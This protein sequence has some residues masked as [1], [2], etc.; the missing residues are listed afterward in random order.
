M[1]NS[2]DQRVTV[3]QQVKTCKNCIIVRRLSVNQIHA[4][5]MKL[6]I[7]LNIVYAE[8]HTTVFIWV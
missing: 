8:Y 7:S 2:R 4:E 6:Y 5:Y 1:Q 3:L